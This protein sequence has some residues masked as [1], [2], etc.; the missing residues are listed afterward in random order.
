MHFVDM[1]YSEKLDR[2]GEKTGEENR[3]VS[4][5]PPVIPA[6]AGIHC[7]DA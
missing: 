6:K 2:S 5:C 4:T 1:L 7:A 3:I